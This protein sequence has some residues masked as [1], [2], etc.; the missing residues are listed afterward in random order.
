MKYMQ[1]PDTP[2]HNVQP[3]TS[4]III[5]MSQYYLYYL[6]YSISKTAA[7]VRYQSLLRYVSHIGIRKKSL[8]NNISMKFTRE[9]QLAC[10]FSWKEQMLYYWVH[11]SYFFASLYRGI[12]NWVWRY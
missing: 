3:I 4:S 10:E 6:Y 9:E 1:P 8:L 11:P 5:L 12:L 7:A 2:P